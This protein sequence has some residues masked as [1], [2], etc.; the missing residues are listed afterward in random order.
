[1][2]FKIHSTSKTQKLRIQLEEHKVCAQ[3]RGRR[4][5]WESHTEERGGGG[6]VEMAYEPVLEA[7]AGRR[8]LEAKAVYL[9][10]RKGREIPGEGGVV[11]DHV[12]AGHPADGRRGRGTPS[13]ARPSED[14]WRFCRHGAH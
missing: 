2:L 14:K 3:G 10:V 4:L 11:L 6:A 12:E 8:E 9:A 13:Q 7:I 1:M 5:R